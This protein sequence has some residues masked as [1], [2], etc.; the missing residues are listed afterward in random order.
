MPLP[1]L[2]EKLR[3]AIPCRGLADDEIQRILE[4]AHRLS[5]PAGQVIC[6]Q[7]DEGNSM[8]IIV[9]GLVKVAVDCGMDKESLLNHL[10]SGEHFGELS[11]LA[12]GPRAATVTAVTTTDLLE[13]NR[14]DVRTIF[15]TVPGFAANLTR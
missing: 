8:F 12:G 5:A 2:L 1:A 15:A 6:K 9:E 10:G 13:I 11:I 4:M 3:N 14:A 7:G